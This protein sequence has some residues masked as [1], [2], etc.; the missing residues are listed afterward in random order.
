MNDGSERVRECW[1]CVKQ[2]QGLRYLVRCWKYG[3]WCAPAS[4]PYEGD[5]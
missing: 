3:R 1:P 5:A 4:A 2:A